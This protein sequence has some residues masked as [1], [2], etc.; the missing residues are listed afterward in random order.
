MHRASSTRSAVRCAVGMT[1]V[2]LAILLC[3]ESAGQ[4]AHDHGSKDG[5]SGESSSPGKQ[6]EFDA[7]IAV[8]ETGLV[9]IDQS[10]SKDNLDEIPRQAETIRLA[11]DGIPPL[12]STSDEY[13]QAA[14]LKISKELSATSVEVSNASVRRSKEEVSERVARMRNLV[15]SLKGTKPEPALARQAPA[16]DAPTN[17]T[18]T[19]GSGMGGHDHHGGSPFKVWTFHPAIVHFPIA[20]LLLGLVIDFVC[21]WRPQEF[22][23]RAAAGLYALGVT[24]GVLAAGSGIAALFTA[25]RLADPG[26]MLWQHPVAAAASMALFAIVAIFRWR[27]RLQPST[28]P[29]LAIAATAAVTLLGAGW[30]G[31][32]LVYSHG[33]GVTPENHG[34]NHDEK[35]SPGPDTRPGSDPH[36]GHSSSK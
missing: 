27:R 24:G 1:T 20:L 21:K 31:H 12:A 23:S 9:A 30:L 2:A 35:K 10:I 34:G 7:A 29:L 18:G 5:K 17:A 4:G 36:A 32:D 3:G 26:P 33:F 16:P 14:I 6:A 28:A 8:I 22:L 19:E 25:P 13:R 15:W 11:A